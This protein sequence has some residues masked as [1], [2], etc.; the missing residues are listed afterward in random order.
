MLEGK[1]GIIPDMSGVRSLAQLV[2]IDT[3]K[4]LTMTAEVL[5]RHRGAPSSGWSPGSPTTRWP[6]PVE[7]V[8]RLRV[9]SPDQLAAAKRLFDD[10]WTA[11]ARRTFARE[12]IEQARLLVGPQHRGRPAGGR[13]RAGARV[14]PP[15]SMTAYR[16]R[17]R[18]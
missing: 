18:A 6:P 16:H 4:R 1:W 15:G 9:R 12:R 11:S 7:L 13:A 2:G 10:T 5:S 14:R 3:A 17:G 8:E